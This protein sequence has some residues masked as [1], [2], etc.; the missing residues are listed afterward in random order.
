MPCLWFDGDADAAV[1]HY[2]AIFP[3]S[4]RVGGSDYLPANRDYLPASHREEGSTLA[5]YFEIDGQPFLAINGGP[6]HHFTPAISLVVTCGTQ[7]EIDYY[8]D[9]LVEGGEPVQ[10]GWLTDRFG[11][12]W[13][14]VPDRLAEL[15]GDPDPARANR[16]MQAL[17]QMV[18]LD[19]AQLEAAAAG[20]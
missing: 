16:A 10:C 11:L 9:R 13:Q 7:E 17:L 6:E 4:R 5:V 3:N 18:K 1:D 20:A 8:W 2:V 14:I 15:L 12:S 19:I